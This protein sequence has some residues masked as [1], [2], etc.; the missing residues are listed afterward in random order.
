MAIAYKNENT[1]TDHFGKVIPNEVAVKNA[2][3]V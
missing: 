3:E 1:S 2:V